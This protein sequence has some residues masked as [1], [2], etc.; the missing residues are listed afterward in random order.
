M[1]RR[2]LLAQ[3]GLVLGTA[4][5]SAQ[6]SPIPQA[7][8]QPNFPPPSF[9]GSAGPQIPA[10]QFPAFPNPAPPGMLPPVGSNLPGQPGYPPMPPGYPGAYSPGLPSPTPIAQPQEIPLP[11]PENKVSLNAGDVSLKRTYTGWQLWAGQRVLRDF[12]DRETDA[13][14]TLQV[15]RDLRP[16]EWVTIGSAKPVVEYALV[17]GRPPAT[18]GMPG[19]GNGNDQNNMNGQGNAIGQASG[20]GAINFGGPAVT[21]AGAKLVLPI[22]LRSVRVEAIRGVWCLRDDNAIHFNFGL[23]KADAQQALAVVQRY[24]FNRIGV[25]GDPAAP[26]MTYF[27]VGADNGLPG[28]KQAQDPFARAALQAQIDGL[29]RVGIPVPGVGY[30]GEMMSIDA[31]KLDVRKDRSDWVVVSGGEV[32]GR[33]GPSEWNARDAARTISDA[34][35]TE[36]CRVGGLTFFLADGKAPTRVPFHTQGR[37]FDPGSLKVQQYGGKWAVME[38]GRHLFDAATAEEGETLVRVVKAFGFDQLCRIGQ[39]N[40]GIPFLAKGQ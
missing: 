29:S 32:L 3:W 7:P 35:F 30:V 20:Q 17:N 18:L 9:P 5:A 6:V 15:Y 37:R 25:V 28:G 34:H 40:T 16:T 11:Q 19:Q 33:F 1:R 2:L 22:D 23:A 8:P 4:T 38:N 36:F 14:D 27:F 10:S 12:G 24:G 39:G 13:R 26:V 21:G 31:R